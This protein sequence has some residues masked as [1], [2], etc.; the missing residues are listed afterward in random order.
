MDGDCDCHA[1]SLSGLGAM[2]EWRDI[3]Q[4][5]VDEFNLFRRPEEQASF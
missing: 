2:S 5:V 1:Y 3:V 4:V